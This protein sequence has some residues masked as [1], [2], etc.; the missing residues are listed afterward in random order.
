[1][2]F[3][4]KNILTIQLL[5]IGWN[6]AYTTSEFFLHLPVRSKPFG[7]NNSCEDGETIHPKMKGGGMNESMQL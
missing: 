6:V 7:M 1:M 2:I 5:V 4:N 3:N